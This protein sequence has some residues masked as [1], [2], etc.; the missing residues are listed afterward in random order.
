MT[1]RHM[2]SREDTS[3]NTQQA[4]IVIK[5]MQMHLNIYIKKNPTTSSKEK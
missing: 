3:E 1:Y 2:G 5:E 4:K